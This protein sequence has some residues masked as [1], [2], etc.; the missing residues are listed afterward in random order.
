MLVLQILFCN[1][2]LLL[3]LLFAF[4]VFFSH[5]T[6]SLPFKYYIIASLRRFC[7]CNLNVPLSRHV[8]ISAGH[9]TL[10][11]DKVRYTFLSALRTISNIAHLDL[12]NHLVLGA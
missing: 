8:E 1:F 9:G 6:F 5:V 3:A 4:L 10:S 7:Y 12:H 11:C 2:H